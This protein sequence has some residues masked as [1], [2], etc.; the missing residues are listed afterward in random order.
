MSSI[1]NIWGN[2]YSDNVSSLFQFGSTN[3]SNSSGNILGIDLTEYSSVTRGS[4]KKLAKAY[5]AKYGKKQ[6]ANESKPESKEDT[7]A[8]TN[9]KDQANALQRAANVLT[10]T[11][12]N[13]VFRKIDIKDEKSGITSKQYD[14]DKIYKAV[15]D[16]VDSY[17]NL[18]KKSADSDS[19]A[20]LRQS[21]RMVN[22]S[23]KNA[24]LL[25]KVGIKINSDNTLSLNEE[26]FKQADMNVVKSLFNG[27]GSFGSGIET[28]ANN[29]YMNINN[30]LGNNATYTA[31]G[32]FGN[33]Q[34]GSL[35]NDLF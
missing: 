17:N 6:V 16:M 29:I 18:I 33:Y 31:G 5:Y 1:N 24:K 11:G 35:L 19:N 12:K 13:S 25:S 34:T 22:S 23:G 4:Y 27:N 10:V 8:K 21:L 28:V 20:V 30:S 2:T 14:T 7:V 26:T 32:T 15:N 9:L 3:S